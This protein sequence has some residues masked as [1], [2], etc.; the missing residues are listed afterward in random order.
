M[1]KVVTLILKLLLLFT[2]NV[3]SGVIR[4]EQPDTISQ[5][6]EIEKNSRASPA[7][8]KVDFK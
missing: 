2:E 5:T 8:I 6:I 7:L 3:F 1:M 4:D